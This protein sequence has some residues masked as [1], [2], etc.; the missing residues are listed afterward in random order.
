MV[1]LL[2]FVKNNSLGAWIGGLSGFCYTLY[3]NIREQLQSL[4]LAKITVNFS[5]M[6]LL[7]MCITVTISTLLGSLVRHLY[8][9]F[10]KDRI[11]KLA[12]RKSKETD[13]E[14]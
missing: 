11:E 2:G 7:W 3:T 8:N 14:Q 10:I 6:D 4:A 9:L 1:E 12:G 13:S 5:L